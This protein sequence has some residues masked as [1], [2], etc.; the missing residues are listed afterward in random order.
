MESKRLGRPPTG[1]A[2]RKT[3]IKGR[4]PTSIYL[5]ADL[6]ES[7][8]GHSRSRG[9]YVFEVLEEIIEAKI[10]KF[11]A[12]DEKMLKDDRKAK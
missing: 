1:N 2:I 11:E 7:L 9:K 5:R 10:K 3:S 12:E 8:A 6:M 4:K